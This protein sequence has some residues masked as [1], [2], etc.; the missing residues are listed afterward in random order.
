MPYAKLNRITWYFSGI[1][2][3]VSSAALPVPFVIAVVVVVVVVVVVNN[4]GSDDRYKDS[5]VVMGASKVFNEFL[6]FVNNSDVIES[7]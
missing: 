3:F 4:N 7:I 5:D 2:V 6:L 1:S